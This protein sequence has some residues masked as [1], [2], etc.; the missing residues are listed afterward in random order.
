MHKKTIWGNTIVYNED[1]YLWFAIKSVINHLDKLLIWDTGSTDNTVKIINQLKKE[2][3]NKIVFKEIGS[4]DA[5][6]LTSARQKMLKE[7]KSDWL[8][9]IDGDEV[10]WDRSI[11]DHIDIINK[12]GGVLYAFVTPVIN[13]VGDI[14]HF[15]DG[16]VGEYRILGKKGHF[17]IRAINRKIPGLHIKNDYPL[18]GFYD[19]DNELIQSFGT[20]KLA[21]MQDDPILHF[22]YLQHSS[23][24]NKVKSAVKRNNTIK[25]ELGNLFPK[26]FKYPEAFYLEYP[27]FV[28]SPWTKMSKQFYYRSLFE[29]PLR[30]IKRKLVN[31]D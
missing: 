24:V 26:N 25:Y 12:E 3:P 29:T 17:N 7:T 22:T 15:Q 19:K 21:L 11:K 14:Y 27:I 13:L 10:W 6:G 31:N 8:L 28:F 23:H 4:V 9:I 5:K 2:Y 30:K 20:Q 1:R 18:E 16:N